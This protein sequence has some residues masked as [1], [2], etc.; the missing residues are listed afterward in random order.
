MLVFSFMTHF[1]GRQ[2]TTTTRKIDF[3]DLGLTVRCMTPRKPVFSNVSGASLLL[4]KPMLEG[5]AAS[6]QRMRYTPLVEV[7]QAVNAWS[8]RQLRKDT[9]NRPYSSVQKKCLR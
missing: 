3:G 1:L 9:F 7:N 5:L 2:S 4:Q 6:R 8:F